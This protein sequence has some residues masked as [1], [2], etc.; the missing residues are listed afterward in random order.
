MA[1]SSNLQLRRR[2]T[3][4]A[5]EVTLLRG[6]QGWAE[7]LHLNEE[8]KSRQ[9]KEGH[10]GEPRRARRR[11][12]GGDS[13]GRRR[14]PCRPEAPAAHGACGPAG[15]GPID[16]GDRQAAG[17]LRDQPGQDHLAAKAGLHPRRRCA[18]RSDHGSPR[19]ARRCGGQRAPVALHGHRSPVR[20]PIPGAVGRTGRGLHSR[21]RRSRQ[22]AGRRAA[23][24]CRCST[25]RQLE[26]ERRRLEGM[27][28]GLVGGDE[29]RAS[30]GSASLDG[31]KLNGLAGLGHPGAMRC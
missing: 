4:K 21:R 24:A 27:A 16:H 3:T 5:G 25:G 13:R 8:A 30:E 10:R 26:T 29:W 19:A 1:A 11:P 15:T 17:V 22:I 18:A 20:A 2:H 12:P 28:S 6:A 14:D 9:S 31:G 23:R 7:T